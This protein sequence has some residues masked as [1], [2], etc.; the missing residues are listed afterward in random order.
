MISMPHGADLRVADVVREVAR[1]RGEQVA[2]RHGERVLS[3][4]QLD[5]RSNRLA[6][7]L[8]AS[9]VREGSRV[10]YLDRTAPEVIE[11]LFAGSKIG[12]VTVPL[13]WRLAARELTAVLE[14][15]QPSVLIAGGAYAQV[16]E[17][18]AGA[19]SPPPEL[20]V[21]AEGHARGYESW[22]RAHDA[23]DPGRRGESDDVVLQLYTSGT[24][25]SRRAS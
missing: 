4:A 6:Q 13:N 10:A 9:G 7:A 16:A 1:A 12:A 11:V 23:S 20:I 25:G 14:D 8:L 21:V 19:L 2:I 17:E 18:I 24:T 15:A 3:Y 5:E 22:L